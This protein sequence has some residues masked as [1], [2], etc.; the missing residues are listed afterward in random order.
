MA[1]R[2]PV[3]PLIDVQTDA[4][5]KQYQHGVVWSLYGDEQG[6]GPVRDIYLVT[7][8]HSCRARGYFDGQHDHWLPHIGFFLGMY[9]G[10][11]LSP[12]TG[13]L[14]PDVTTLAILTNQHAS[15]GYSTGREDFFTGLDPKSAGIPSKPCCNRSGT[16]LLNRSTG[17]SRSMFGSTTLD[18]CLAN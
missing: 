17:K 14:R 12:E 4:F 9:H 13:Q 10:G 6:Q 5:A 2:P 3:S 11:V 8:L 18:V 16:L 1:Q 15:D 7:N